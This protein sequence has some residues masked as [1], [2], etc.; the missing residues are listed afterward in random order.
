MKTIILA[1][2]FALGISLAAASSASAAA[3]GNGIGRAA[4][5]I[6]PLVEARYY[7]RRIRVCE[8]RYHHRYCHYR[9]VCRHWHW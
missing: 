1:M 5:S 8:W 2:L 9:R 6:S 7:C 3:I 4:E